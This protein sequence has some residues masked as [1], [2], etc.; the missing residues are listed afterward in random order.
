MSRI[1]LYPGSFDPP[2]RGHEDLIR[3]AAMLADQLVVAVVGN[4]SKQ[5]VFTT[6][7]RLDL[8]RRTVGDLPNVRFDAFEGLLA[9][10]AR[11]IG[12]QFLVRGLRAVGDFEYEFQMALMNRQLHPGL[13]TVF[14]VP[15]SGLTYV[16]ASLVREVAR[17][18]GN[19]GPL[20]HPVVAEAL[21]RRFGR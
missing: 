17:F 16:S 18:G 12:A 14:L 3:R 21:A 8:L 4:P 7:E 10:Y 6:E 11:R 19:V 1:A 13:E 20:V 5:P 9:D 15:A 2:T